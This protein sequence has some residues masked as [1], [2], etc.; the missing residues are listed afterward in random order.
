MSGASLQPLGLQ[1]T[2]IRCG[3]AGVVSK[4]NRGQPRGIYTT[5][6][7]PVLFPALPGKVPEKWVVLAR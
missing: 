7:N 6:K 1:E 3:Q 4:V 5:V 2:L